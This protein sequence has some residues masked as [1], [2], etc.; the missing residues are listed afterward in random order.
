MRVSNI[1][2]M[3]VVGLGSHV[4]SKGASPAA[5]GPRCAL[6]VSQYLRQGA[7]HSPGVQRTG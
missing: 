2:I 4:V 6:S 3:A 7:L 5:H 1:A